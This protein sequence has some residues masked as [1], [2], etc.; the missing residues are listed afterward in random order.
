[1]VCCLLIAGATF[2]FD[3]RLF[4]VVFPLAVIVTGISAV[5]LSRVQHEVYGMIKSVGHHLKPSEH[6]G[7]A[8][9]MPVIVV[10]DGREI[11]WY[12]ELFEQEVV[13]GEELLGMSFNPVSYTHLD[14]Y[15]RQAESS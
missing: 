6:S 5:F 12:N 4:Y 1:M 13:V 11:I 2:F 3:K 8:F 15:K 9:P 7:V 10:S 14:V